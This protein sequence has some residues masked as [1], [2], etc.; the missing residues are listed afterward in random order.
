MAPPHYCCIAAAEKD[1]RLA[2]AYG[3]GDYFPDQRPVIPGVDDLGGPALD[4]S[5]GALE[6]RGSF[7]AGGPG[8]SGEA[9]FGNSE[10]R[11]DRSRW[12]LDRKLMAKWPDVLERFEQA[13]SAVD[14]DQNQR[15]VRAKESRKR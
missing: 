8:Y 15:R 14:G 12:S 9:A 11:T 5:D 6:E 3:C 13:T 7:G 4:R 10:N 1:Q 2:F